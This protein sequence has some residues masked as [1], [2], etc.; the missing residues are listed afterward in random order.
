MEQGAGMCKVKCG[1]HEGIYIL[2]SM[3]VTKSKTGGSTPV[4]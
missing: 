1:S 2:L 4:S 3:C